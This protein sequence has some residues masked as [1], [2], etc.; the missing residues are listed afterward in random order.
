MS[1]SKDHP[2]IWRAANEVRV[3]DGHDHLA[4]EEKRITGPIDPL[5]TLF[6]HY[7]PS[8]LVSAGMPV[9]D[10]VYI[11]KHELPLAERWERFSPYWEKI[12]NTGYARTL[13]IA[14]K[15]LYGVNGI[16][17]DTYSELAVKMKQANKKGLYNWILREKA[18]IDVAILD[19][20]C[21]GERVDE[22]D[23]S[24]FAP[25]SRL[26]DFL[27]PRNADDISRLSK[28]VGKP[29]HTLKELVDCF[30]LELERL[31]PHI[32]G[33]KMAHAYYRILQF[34]KVT[35]FE[36]ER[37][38]NRIHS[39]RGFNKGKAEDVYQ[40]KKHME[41]LSWEESKPLHDFM[42]HK[43]I[44]QGIRHGLPIQIHTGLHEG[45]EN[46][47]SNSN[48]VHLVNLFLEYTDARFVIFHGS[49]PYTGELSVLAKNF[50]NVYLDMAWL[51]IISP[52]ATRRALSEWLD[53][54]PG[55][56]IIGFGG[57]FRFVEGTYGHLKIARNNIA[58]T[59]IDKVQNDSYTTKEAISLVRRLLRD[60]ALE[61]YLPQGFN[62]D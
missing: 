4:P 6:A 54:V 62:R 2:E 34:D 51:H 11:R 5:H 16:T 56:K 23:K 10:L 42:I 57:D 13:N 39:Q 41:Q 50:P 49:Y 38:F 14:V 1:S 12:Q 24:F 17:S 46:I 26:E 27:I 30:E 3:I 44:Q 48:P 61:L 36:A 29:I 28:K 59:L 45:N 55:N 20:E 33:L 22:V 7:A 9:Q 35:F 52:S 37:A 43:M 47:I 60:N 21:F 58:L 18:G 53:T 31:R 8:D 15:D 40:A 25:V 32:V 19:C